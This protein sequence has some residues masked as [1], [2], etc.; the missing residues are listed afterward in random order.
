[1]TPRADTDSACAA[2]HTHSVGLT[3]K[4]RQEKPPRISHGNR[5]G[6]GCFGLLEAVVG[7]R[8]GGDDGVG[9]DTGEGAVLVQQAAPLQLSP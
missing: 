3:E 7:S 4:Y 9:D 5:Q 1:M 8:D 6:S 2:L